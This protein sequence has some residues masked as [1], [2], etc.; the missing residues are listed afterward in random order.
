[1]KEYV[2]I[3]NNEYM[4]YTKIAQILSPDI[5]VVIIPIAK[6]YNYDLQ[7]A[8]LLD[9]V[10]IYEIPQATNNVLENAAQNYIKQYPESIYKGNI[11]KQ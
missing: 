6:E 2:F 9:N 5:L 3:G 7:N 11:Q 10:Y 1:M 8:S 4:E